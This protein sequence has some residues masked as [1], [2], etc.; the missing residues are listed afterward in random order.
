M[1]GAHRRDSGHAEQP[2]GLDPA[3]A[4]YDAVGVVNQDRIDKAEFLDT[5]SNLSDFFGLCVRGLRSPHLSWA[6]P[7]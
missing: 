7:L 6:G 1:V 3:M 2:C 5:G 4:C